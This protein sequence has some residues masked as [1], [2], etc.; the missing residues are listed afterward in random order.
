MEVFDKPVTKETQ[1][2][3]VFF[4]DLVKRDHT[5]EELFN[6]ITHMSDLALDHANMYAHIV[7]ALN[8]DKPEKLN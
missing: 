3:D 2:A 8:N 1:I 4:T 7:K 6:I 5:I